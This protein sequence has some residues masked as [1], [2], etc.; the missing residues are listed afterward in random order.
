MRTHTLVRGILGD[1]VDG[2]CVLTSNCLPCNAAQIVQVEDIPYTLNGKRV[3]V[4]VK[5]VGI[6]LV[7]YVE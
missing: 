4:P 1:Y 6:A 7:G 2:S 3:E 5:K